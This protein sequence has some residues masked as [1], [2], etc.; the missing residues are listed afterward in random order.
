MRLFQAGAGLSTTIKYNGLG[1]QPVLNTRTGRFPASPTAEPT[2]PDTMSAAGLYDASRDAE[3]RLLLRQNQQDAV[4]RTVEAK[5][6]ALAQ[7]ISRLPVPESD[8]VSRVKTALSP[9]PEVFPVTADDEA[10]TKATHTTEVQWPTQGARINSKLLN[11]VAEVDLADGE[12]GFTL[13]VDGQEH[14]LVISVNN[15]GAPDAWESFLGM[16][17]GAV[18]TN[19]EMLQRL[20]IAISGADSRVGAEVEYVEVD[21]YDPSP[22]SSPMNR[23]AR[24]RI[25]STEDGAGPDIT[26]TDDSGSLASGLGLNRGAPARQASVRVDSVLLAQ[27]SDTVS[28]DHGHVLGAALGSTNGKIDIQVVQ[29]AGPITEALAS[30][31]AGYNDLVSYLHANSDLLRPSLVDRVTRPTE[32]TAN[33]LTT[34]GLRAT[35]TGRLEMGLNQDQRMMAD[36]A[37]TRAILLSQDGWT[38]RLAEKL[39]QIQDTGVD[40]F[41]AE[42]A[43]GGGLGETRRA[44]AL[45]D[46]LSSGIVNGYF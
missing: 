12:H 1:D 25:F 40:A 35:S 44:W 37:Q 15:G 7:K 8:L 17:Q 33:Q 18:D 43:V 20:A 36:F 14:Q 10:D 45:L 9:K 3:V 22:R 19:E 41:A 21:A 11:P 23:M 24:L 34:I 29:G 6:K 26:L 30:V 4:L 39:T 28:L 31:V 46:S 2:G 5:V 27:D 16:S 38:T 42:L 32:Q 13:T